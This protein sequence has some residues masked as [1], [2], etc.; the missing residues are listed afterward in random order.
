[1][2]EPC[3]VRGMAWCSLGPTGTRTS[4]AGSPAECASQSLGASRA[5]AS[6]AWVPAGAAVP[7]LCPA[8][9][10]LSTRFC[11]LGVRGHDVSGV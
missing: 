4:R 10:C 2:G 3:G 5:P 6:A 8:G 1:M 11:L 7:T 9:D